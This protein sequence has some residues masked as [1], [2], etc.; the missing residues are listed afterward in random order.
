M[1]AIV[2]SLP[3]IRESRPVVT[4]DGR[5]IDAFFGVG[6]IFE[7]CC[8]NDWLDVREELLV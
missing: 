8:C 1:D 3:S 7:T 6:M 2:D 5:E 4:P